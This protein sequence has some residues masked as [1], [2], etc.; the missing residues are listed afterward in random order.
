[1]WTDGGIGAGAF[2]TSVFQTRTTSSPQHLSLTSADYAD[3]P[4]LSPSFLSSHAC[5]TKPMMSRLP[6]DNVA[7]KAPRRSRSS[8]TSHNSPPSLGGLSGPSCAPQARQAHQVTNDAAES[9]GIVNRRHTITTPHIVDDQLASPEG[10]K[11]I[12]PRPGRSRQRTIDGEED[13]DDFAVP[14]VTI[15][16]NKAGNPRQPSPPAESPLA[17]SPSAVSPSVESPSVGSPADSRMFSE[18]AAGV[19]AQNPRRRRH[20]RLPIPRPRYDYP[21]PKGLMDVCKALGKDSWNHYVMLV[22]KKVMGRLTEET[23]A[24]E[25]KHLFMMS[26]KDKANQRRLDKQMSDFVTPLLKNHLARSLQQPIKE[27]LVA[28][29]TQEAQTLGESPVSFL[30]A[31]VVLFSF[32]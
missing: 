20:P 28:E 23:F 15:G 16:S 24:R 26:H 14:M 22:E 19:D 3:F 1:M 8:N 12:P 10:R 13:G 21:V 5:I 6:P 30:V 18:R 4:H 29:S 11:T 27:K 2:D 31:K 32:T 25:K 7:R 9:N 17:E